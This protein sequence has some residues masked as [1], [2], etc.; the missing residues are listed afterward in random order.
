[1]NFIKRNNALELS[2]SYFIRFSGFRPCMDQTRQSD[3]N[4]GRADK[5]PLSKADRLA[6]SL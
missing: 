2:Q 4:I 1:M 5:I 6:N 3:F